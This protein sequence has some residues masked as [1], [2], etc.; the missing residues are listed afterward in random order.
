MSR[1]FSVA[2]PG[3]EIPVTISQPESISASI[4]APISPELP[5]PQITEHKTSPAYLDTIAAALDVA[6]ARILGLLAI[7]GALAIWGA[8]VWA[9][10]PMRLG[11]ATGYS[12]LVLMPTMVLYMRKG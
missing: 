8:A 7:I 2:S 3:D 1:L 6:S 12:M 5:P 4:S 9:P 11:A 10:E